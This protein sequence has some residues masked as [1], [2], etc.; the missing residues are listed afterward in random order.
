[1]KNLYRRQGGK[2]QG[3]K[4]LTARQAIEQISP[5][6]AEQLAEMYDV[7]RYSELPVEE[8]SVNELKKELR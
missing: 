2:I 8:D 4:T 1:M 5:R 3:L 7:A 6:C